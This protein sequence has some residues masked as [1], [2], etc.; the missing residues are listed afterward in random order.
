MIVRDAT[1]TRLS[2]VAAERA[3]L[4]TKAADD[5]VALAD[6]ADAVVR[7]LTA[8]QAVIGDYQR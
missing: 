2:A 7:Q 8:C 6:D 1:A 3:K 4:A 5:L